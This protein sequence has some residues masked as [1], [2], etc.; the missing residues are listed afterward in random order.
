MSLKNMLAGRSRTL[1]AAQALYLYA[2][3]PQRG[4]LQAVSWDK[5]SPEH[6]SVYLREADVALRAA[7]PTSN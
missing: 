3:R 5:L 1:L 2:T 6:Q 7:D 4:C